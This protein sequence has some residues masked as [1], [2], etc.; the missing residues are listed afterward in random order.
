MGVIVKRGTDILTTVEVEN[1]EKT[2]ANEIAANIANFPAYKPDGCGAILLFHTPDHQIHGLGGLRAN[3]ALKDKLTSD[4]TRFPPQVNTTIGGRLIDPEKPLQES[5]M[6][7]I[8]YK[9]FFDA[10]T[11]GNSPIYKEQQIIKSLI[12]TIET[13]AGWASDVCVHT[14]SWKNDDTSVGTMCFLTGIKHINCSNEDL[15][16]IENALQTIMDYKKSQGEQ[17]RNLSDFK[18]YPFI[19]TMKNATSGYLIERT[20]LEKAEIAHKNKAFVTFNDLCLETFRVNGSYAK[21]QNGCAELS[22]PVMKNTT[23]YKF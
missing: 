5:I 2:S 4:E 14:D 16:E 15:R 12:T 18:F 8:K 23:V 11:P 1:I 20:E 3:P 17:P 21:G 7:A 10:N 13:S 22:L 6:N 19:N 9:M